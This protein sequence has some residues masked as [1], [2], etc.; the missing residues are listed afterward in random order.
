[1]DFSK[2]AVV[3]TQACQRFGLGQSRKS[4]VYAIGQSIGCSANNQG[5][6][7]V[8]FLAGF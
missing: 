3:T 5:T 8:N 1:V 4:I 6:A 2:S 7:P